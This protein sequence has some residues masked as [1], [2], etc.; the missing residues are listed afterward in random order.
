MWL[1]CKDICERENVFVDSKLFL[2]FFVFGDERGF[3][4][5]SVVICKKV[6]CV[7]FVG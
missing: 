6:G 1:S 4:L 2:S 7:D 5:S 3:W